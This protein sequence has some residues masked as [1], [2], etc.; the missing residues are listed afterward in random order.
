MRIEI[1]QNDWDGFCNEVLEVVDNKIN[2][3]NKTLEE[4]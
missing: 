4:L 2:E 1:L 3:H